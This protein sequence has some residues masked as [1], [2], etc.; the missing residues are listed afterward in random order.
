MFIEYAG[1]FIL[2]LKH[3]L[4]VKYQINLHFEFEQFSKNSFTK[5]K[6]SHGKFPLKNVTLCCFY[7]C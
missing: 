1:I 7:F 2:L 6:H 5:H 4:L 3:I